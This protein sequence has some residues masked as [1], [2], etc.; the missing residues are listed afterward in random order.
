MGHPP[1]GFEEQI[2]PFLALLGRR[3][4]KG[5]KSPHF[6]RSR[7][8]MGHPPA[9]FEEQIP[10][11]LALLGRRN[12]KGMKSPHFRQSRPEMGHPSAGSKSRFLLSSLCSGVGMTRE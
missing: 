4:D 8:E 10:P 6:R 9:G 12:D 7:P 3:N 2:P 1:A 5:M 11:F